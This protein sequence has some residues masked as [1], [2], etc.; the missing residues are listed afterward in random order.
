M[1]RDALGTQRHQDNAIFNKTSPAKFEETLDRQ[2][3]VDPALT[4]MRPYGFAIES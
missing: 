1:K 2:R 4:S 3:R